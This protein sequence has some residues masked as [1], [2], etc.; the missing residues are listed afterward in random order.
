M[1]VFIF[2]SLFITSP[3]F[4][5]SSLDEIAQKIW[6]NECKGSIDGLVSWNEGEEFAS[7]GIG[8]FI[9][10]PTNTQGPFKETFPAFLQFLKEQDITLPQWLLTT[11]GCP[12]KSRQE[13]LENRDCAQAREL[14]TL[15]TQTISYQAAFILKRFET[16]SS[17]LMPDHIK[18]QLKRILASSQG[19]YILLDYLNFKGEGTCPKERYQGFGW[20]LLQVLELMPGTSDPI[21][22]FVIAA[23]AVL[24]RRVENSP[25]ER[26]EQRWLRGWFNRVDTYQ[27][28]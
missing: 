26:G 16:A 24:K 6:R 18:H 28:P 13:F 4:A 9:W 5:S 7:L 19:Q 11:Q 3:L 12:W 10:Y 1:H 25:P 23:K 14:R 22:E 20:G 21:E 15:L 2:I 27:T 8:H 17:E